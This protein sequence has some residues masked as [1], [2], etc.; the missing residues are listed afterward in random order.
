MATLELPDA[1]NQQSRIATTPS[2]RQVFV[3]ITSDDRLKVIRRLKSRWPE[4]IMLREQGYTLEQIRDRLHIRQEI[5]DNCRGDCEPPC[6]KDLV[7]ACYA[8][9]ETDLHQIAADRAKLM[10]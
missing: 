7:S 3:P 4:V 6:F 10:V 1:R 2:G 9:I 8:I 5:R